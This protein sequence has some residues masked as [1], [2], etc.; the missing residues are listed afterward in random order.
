MRLQKKEN[1]GSAQ[2]YPEIMPSPYYPFMSLA[3]S[4]L[5][6]EKKA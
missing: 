3:S 2:G 5:E 1:V 4:A 6:K